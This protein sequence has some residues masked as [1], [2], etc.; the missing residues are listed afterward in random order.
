[1]VESNC[2]PNEKL[3]LLEAAK[4]LVLPQVIAQVRPKTPTVVKPNGIAR[5]LFGH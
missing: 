4:T 3:A 1:M 5:R 2:S